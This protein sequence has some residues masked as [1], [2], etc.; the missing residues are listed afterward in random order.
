MMARQRLALIALLLAGLAT[1]LHMGVARAGGGRSR[2]PVV[3]VGAAVGRPIAPSFLGVSMEYGTV[4]AYESAEPNGSDPVLAQLI[5]NLSPG[6]TPIIRIGGDSTD[7]SY[8]PQPGLRPPAGVRTTLSDQWLATAQ[9]LVQSTGARLILG[10]NMEADRPSIA[11]VEA[12]RLLAGIGASHL[13]ALELGNEPQLY[14]DRPW[15]FTPGGVPVYGRKHG[16]TLADYISEFARFQRFLPPVPLA[17]PSIG[18]SWLSQLNGFIDW[19][20]GQRMVT[21]HA[22]AANPHGSAFRGRDCSTPAGTS[23]YP[24]LGGLLAPTAS[25]GLTR[26]LA[27]AIALAHKRGFTFRV[28]E[29]NAITC[30]GMPGISDTFASS[31]WALD[32]LFAMARAGVDGVN[33]HTWRGSAG[34]LFAFSR[35][36]NAWLGSVRPEYYGLLMFAQAVPPGSRLLNTA[37]TNTGALQAW[38]VRAPDGST[39]VVLVN[40]SVSRAQSVTVLHAP[41]HGTATV[42]RLTAPSASATT[43][44]ELGC[45]SFGSETPTGT[46]AGP[47]CVYTVYPHGG[48]YPLWL[49]P[50]SALL[51]TISPPGPTTTPTTTTTTPTPP[52][53]TTT[54]TP[55]PS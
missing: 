36:N 54:T 45:Q 55:A 35:V 6:Q 10:I 8:W 11:V 5:R 3:T 1:V 24:T 48:R 42:D 18:R 41:T 20:R 27:P 9:E 43:G 31:L 52:P 34:K 47:S 46:L 32:T 40:N 21:F 13:E 7:W 29:L 44:V 37:E 14:P 2:A 17:G 22:Y 50:A 39:R 30:A 19:G 12:Q 33:V 4:G 15:Y 25:I 51:L 23:T 53:T 28:D 16:Y 26:G 38:A 49:P